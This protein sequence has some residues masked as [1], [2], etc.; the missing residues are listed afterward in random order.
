MRWELDKQRKFFQSVRNCLG[1]E[2]VHKKVEKLKTEP[3][4]LENWKLYGIFRITA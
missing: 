3:Q 4:Y 1:G 2:M